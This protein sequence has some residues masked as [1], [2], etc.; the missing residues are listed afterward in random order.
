MTPNMTSG[1]GNG[2][3]ASTECGAPNVKLNI[4]FLSLGSRGDLRTHL[5]IAK[6]LQHHYGHRVRFGTHD[7]HKPHVE[8]AG[9][10]FYF[11]GSVDPR[12]MMR[13]RH[14]PREEI[15]KMMPMIKDEFQ[16]MGER[17]WKAC[18]N[19]PAGIPSGAAPA[20]FVADVVAGGMAKGD[21]VLQNK[22][23]WWFQDILFFQTFKSLMIELR[24][25]WMGLEP[26]T[27]LWY[28]SQW[29]RL[30]VPFTNTWSPDFLPA[31]RDWGDHI[32][33]AG[34][35]FHDDPDYE[36]PADLERFLE[37]GDKPIYVG[38]GSMPFLEPLKVFQD[39]CEGIEKAGVRAVV[40]LGLSGLETD[41]FD[42]PQS[43]FLTKECPHDWLFPRVSAVV[44]HGGAGTTAMALRCGRPIVM[45]PV[46][47][48]QPFWANRVVRAGCGPEPLSTAQLTADKL[49]GRIKDVL[50]PKYAEA[51]AGMAAK[52]ASEEPGQ[53]VFAQRAQRT[54]SIYDSKGRCDVFPDKPAVW[55]LASSRASKLSA[56]AAHVLVREG[57]VSQTDLERLMLVKLPDLASPGDPLSGSI[58]AVGRIASS[59]KA[60]V[61]QMVSNGKAP[62][63][64]SNSEE[65]DRVFTRPELEGPA[66]FP[67]WRPFP[68][69]PYTSSYISFGFY[70]LVDFIAYGLGSHTEPD[71]FASNPRLYS[72]G[73]MIG[74]RLAKPIKE[75]A[76]VA[77]RP[78]QLPFALLRAVDIEASRSMGERPKN[79]VVAEAWIRHGR[80]EA[81][82]LAQHS[83]EEG[84]DL[85]SRVLKAWDGRG[86]TKDVAERII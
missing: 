7:T 78:A 39:V 57:K 40:A 47:G 38:F 68:T 12:E 42:A 72:Y 26:F 28:M 9:V 1:A 46:A 17:Y 54:F 74:F 31:P 45:C 69:S 61:K 48:D 73:Q 79:D 64:I 35:M 67:Y 82:Y 51:A 21:S 3:S 70:N 5:E 34:F 49:V 10:E 32:D 76:S 85:T 15:T 16:T 80:L 58:L 65:K 43:V 25:E 56:V 84:A 30:R 4:V 33:I 50:N 55:K 66:G 27:P 86:G 24:V 60:D 11:S 19:D 6:T 36:A 23:S 77:Q 75:L 14:L 63:Q 2:T 18:V 29:N 41:G 22:F 13:R 62:E 83:I 53:E 71:L 52:I 8:A 37:A 81:E 59:I 44:I 20:P